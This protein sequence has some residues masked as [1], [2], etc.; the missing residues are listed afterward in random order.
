MK[1]RP[2]H[3]G[4]HCPCHGEIK[5]EK[6]LFS[7]ICAVLSLTSPCIV[8]LPEVGIG[9]GRCA[10]SGTKIGYAAGTDI[11]YAAGTDIGYAATRHIRCAPRHSLR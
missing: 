8:L 5:C 2:L 3:A 4:Q 7:T 11:G 6:P 10:M 1:D 9:I